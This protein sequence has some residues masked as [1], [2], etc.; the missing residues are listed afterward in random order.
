MSFI[1]P[2][3]HAFIQE[4][5]LCPLMCQAWVLKTW[6]WG[7]N[8]PNPKQLYLS[9]SQQGEVGNMR[10]P[11]RWIPIAIIQPIVACLYQDGSTEG[12][13]K[14]SES[15]HPKDRA[16]ICW[17]FEERRET[18]QGYLKGRFERGKWSYR[19]WDWSYCKKCM[20]TDPECGS[21]H[22][23]E[24]EKR[25]MSP[26]WWLDK[27][28]PRRWIKKMPLRRDKEEKNLQLE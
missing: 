10:K 27:V 9:Y 19:C 3:T 17:G 11:I 1:H 21:G 24:A 8:V 23:H 15:R 2:V 20:D 25:R 13:R 4:T 14:W 22:V 12:F 6:P 5:A 28:A 26:G 16:K 7:N 18:I